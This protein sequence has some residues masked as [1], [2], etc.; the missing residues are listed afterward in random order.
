MQTGGRIVDFLVHSQ[1]GTQWEPLGDGDV[2]VRFTDA[3][4]VASFAPPGLAC[5][6][7]DSPTAC[8]VGCILWPLCGWTDEAGCHRIVIFAGFAARLVR[9]TM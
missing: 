5:S 9:D 3:Q 4:P 6:G 8:A 2:E 7:G 1:I